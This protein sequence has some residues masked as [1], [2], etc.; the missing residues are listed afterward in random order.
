MHRAF[1]LTLPAP[2]ASVL[3]DERPPEAVHDPKLDGIVRTDLIANQTGLILLPYDASFTLDNRCADLCVDAFVQLKRPDGSGGA[4]LA[5]EIAV[6]L[7]WRE[8]QVQS[9]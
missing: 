3:R 7:A 1:I 6:L 8:S 9:R 4:N 5:A 2:V